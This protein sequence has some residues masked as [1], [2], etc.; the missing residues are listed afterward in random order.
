MPG[1]FTLFGG[2]KT[3]STPWKFNSNTPQMPFSRTK[4]IKD[5]T[6]N[7]ENINPNI[8]QTIP[9]APL[10]PLTCVSF[11]GARNM[12]YISPFEWKVLPVDSPPCDRVVEEEEEMGDTQEDT[13]PGRMASC[14]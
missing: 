9:V 13:V 12:V 3:G 14:A 10:V 2:Y 6:S 1:I 4:T 5:T 7:K 8:G 11:E